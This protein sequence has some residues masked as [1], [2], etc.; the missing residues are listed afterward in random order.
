MADLD[1]IATVLQTAGVGTVGTD[2][3]KGRMPH[4]PAACTSLQTYPGMPPQYIQEQ[5]A[6][7]YERPAFQLVVRNPDHVTAETKARLAFTT[8]AA[9]RNQTASGV[10]FVAIRPFQSPFELP[11]DDNN[12]VLYAFN[13]EA[14]IA[15]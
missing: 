10:R 4:E 14:L 2:L 8:L 5:A 15:R 3:F 1:A 6:P 13:F 12:R 7:G 11:R 9:I